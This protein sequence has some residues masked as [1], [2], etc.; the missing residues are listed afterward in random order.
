MNAN[1]S[2][3]DDLT[4]RARKRVDMKMGFTVHL[5]VYLLVNAG[6]YLLNQVKGGGAWHVWPLAGWGVGLA[7]HGIVTLIGLQGDGLRERMLANE[8]ERLKG[9]R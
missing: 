7:I 9:R 2:L 6:L 3:D 5:L 8:I 1:L 4:R